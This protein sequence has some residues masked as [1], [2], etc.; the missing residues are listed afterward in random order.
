MRKSSY[1]VIYHTNVGNFIDC[2]TRFKKA[3][4]VIFSETQSVHLYSGH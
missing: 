1:N 3:Y 4:M 2:I